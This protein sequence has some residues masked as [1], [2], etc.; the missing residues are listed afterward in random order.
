M[1]EEGEIRDWRMGVE[2]RQG[3]R[4]QGKGGDGK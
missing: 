1:R 4:D 2:G 3:S